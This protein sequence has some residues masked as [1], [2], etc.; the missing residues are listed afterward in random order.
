MTL[1]KT[2]RFLRLDWSNLA[3]MNKQVNGG[4]QPQ[5]RVVAMTSDRDGILVLVVSE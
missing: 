2:Y 5:E 1:P 4:L 3:E